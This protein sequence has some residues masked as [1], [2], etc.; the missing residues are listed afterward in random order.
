MNDELQ[1]EIAWISLAVDSFAMEMKNKMIAKAVKGYRGW[2]NPDLKP[3]I[4]AMLLE[5]VERN[6]NGS[7][8][9]DIARLAMMLYFLK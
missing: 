6:E 8:S 3:T 4:E 7:Q 1:T 5:H 9:I 2:Q